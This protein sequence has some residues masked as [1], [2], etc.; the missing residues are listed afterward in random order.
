MVHGRRG[1]G[2]VS[3]HRPTGAFVCLGVTPNDAG[4]FSFAPSSHT[5]LRALNPMIDAKRGGAVSSVREGFRAMDLPL[6]DG[7]PFGCRNMTV[8]TLPPSCS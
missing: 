1:V 4:L 5:D 8:I 7:K 2:V 3:L 6:C